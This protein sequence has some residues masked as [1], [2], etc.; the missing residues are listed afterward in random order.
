MN[1][2]YNIKTLLL[3]MF[4]IIAVTSCDDSDNWE[5]GPQPAPNNPGVYFSGKIPGVI[6]IEANSQGNLI[7]DHFTIELG[8]DKL[9]SNSALEVPVIIHYVHPNLTVSDKVVFEAGASTAQLKVVL[10]DF[11]FATEYDLS[12]EID[13]KFANPYL[14]Y[15]NM[16]NGGSSRLDTKVQVLSLLGVATFKATPN[17]GSI[18]PDF[19]PFEQKIYDN[20]DGTYTIKNF[21]LNN[22][23]F[24]FDFSVDEDNNIWP[25]ETCGYHDTSELR[26]YFHSQNSSS[27]SYRIP[28]YIPGSN[29]D[30]EIRYIYFYTADN[31]SS[32]TDFWLDT[33]SKTGK[34]SGYSRYT[35]SSS[36]QLV[37]DFSWD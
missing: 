14:S 10:D 6:E 23:G 30:D 8:R 27:S 16:E 37:F 36:G 34:M 2:I 7:K 5:A 26:W 29:P 12:I 20:Q 15:E 24:D 9:K 33:T 28:C 4:T 21:L 18:K 3:A 35:E 22:A 11:E 32:R 13:E 1:K 17:S 31:S 19:Y 25:L